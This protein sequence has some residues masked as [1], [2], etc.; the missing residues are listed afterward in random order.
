MSNK[1]YALPMVLG[2]QYIL[3]NV[4]RETEDTVVYAAMQKDM[5]R[6]VLVESL[7][8]A[9]MQDPAKVSNFLE[10]AR[11][12]ASI[13]AKVV[14]STLELI[15]AEGSWHL[16]KE[17]IKGEPLDVMVSTGRKLPALVLCNLFLELCHAAIY[18]DI[19]GV[20][21]RPMRPDAIYLMDHGFRFEN[22]ACAGE[23]SSK[24]TPELLSVLA[25]DLLPLLDASSYEA[26]RMGEILRRV[27]YGCNW[28]PMSILVLDEELVRLQADIIALI[29]G[30]S[31]ASDAGAPG[32]VEPRCSDYL[33]PPAAQRSTGTDVAANSAPRPAVI[34]A[35]PAFF[36]P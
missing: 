19:R 24:A 34:P 26:F 32:A 23:R 8:P 3:S 36:D 13:P 31:S 2:D 17:R 7:S 1:I 35:A 4:V 27:R 6:E 15:Q 5:R 20:N 30:D 28:T 22:L 33:P 11:I 16:T 18:L 9:A 21:N 29:E 12:Q 10:T 14:A 25:A